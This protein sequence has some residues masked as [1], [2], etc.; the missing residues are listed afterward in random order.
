MSS[1]YVEFQKTGWLRGL[2][3]M[4]LGGW[5]LFQPGM[6]FGL[7]V[8]VVAAVLL[9][10][11]IMNIISGIRLQRQTGA[12]FGVG[13]GVGLILA[14]V[15]VE[16]FAKVF[17]AMF[18]LFIGIGL[19]IYGIAAMTGA[20]HNRQY[21]NVSSTSGIV[22]GLLVVIAGLF[23]MFNPFGS[24]MLIFRFFGGVILFMGIMEVINWFK[25]R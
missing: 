17:L 5:I 21:V 19:L 2:I 1:F 13:S 23:M 4:A 10:M 8:N 7:L 24:A 11:G 20:Q 9:V 15:L 22:Y 6:V 14:A 16:A 3:M 12:S 18:P 25:F